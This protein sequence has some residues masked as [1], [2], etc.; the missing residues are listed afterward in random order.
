MLSGEAKKYQFY[1]LW[2]ARSWLEP[3]IYHT[4]GE[5]ANNYATDAIPPTQKL[6]Q[7]NTNPIVRIDVISFVWI[8]ARFGR[9]IWILNMKHLLVSYGTVVVK[10]KTWQRQLIQIACEYTEP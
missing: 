8:C 2:F 9:T 4:R 6:K 5:H 1:S 3:K 10:L 7:N